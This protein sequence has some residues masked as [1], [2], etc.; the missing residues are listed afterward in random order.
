MTYPRKHLITLDDTPYYHCVARCVRRAWLWGRDD[1]SGKDYSH[2]KSWVVDQLRLLANVFAMDICAYAVM[3]NHY[4]VVLRVNRAMAVQ[5]PATEVIRRWS[6]LFGLPTLIERYHSGQ[7]TRQNE[8]EAALALINVWRGRLTDISWFMRCLNEPLA[9]KANAEE[10]CKGRFWEGRYKSQAL[11][12]DAGL[13]TAML[14]VDLNPIRAGI[15]QTPEQSIFTSVYARIQQFESARTSDYATRPPHDSGPTPV[16]LLSFRQPGDDNTIPFNFT[17]YL[18]LLDWT[19]RAI[20]HDKRGHIPADLPAILTRLRIDPIAWRHTMKPQGNRFGSA[21][22]QIDRLRHYAHRLGQFW[23][24]G[25]GL[26]QRLYGMT[27]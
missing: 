6:Q 12:D 9:R 26:S 5:W 14:Y 4:H 24:R 18:E 3:S 15:T 16:T 8:E 10:G 22:G 20:R 11:L 19:G 25:V 17:D 2:R 27:A 21:I 23:V 7:V 1:L 13:L